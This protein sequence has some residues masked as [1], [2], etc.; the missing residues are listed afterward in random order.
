MVVPEALRGLS[1]LEGTVGVTGLTA[2][3][4]ACSGGAWKEGEFG[5]AGKPGRG[6][7]ASRAALGARIDPSG[8]AGSAMVPGALTS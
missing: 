4:G 7:A 1:P 2:P 5:V 8:R 3:T 6:E